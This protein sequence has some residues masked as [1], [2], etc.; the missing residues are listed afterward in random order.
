MCWGGRRSCWTESSLR[1][2]GASSAFWVMIPQGLQGG[3]V[4]PLYQHPG[5]RSWA[6]PSGTKEEPQGWEGCTLRSGSVALSESKQGQEEAEEWPGEGQRP[7]PPPR[8]GRQGRELGG[9]SSGAG[10]DLCSVH[11]HMTQHLHTSYWIGSLEE[12]RLQPDREGSR[13]TAA[14]DVTSHRVRPWGWA[15]PCCRGVTPGHGVRGQR[16]GPGGWLF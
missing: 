16:G 3:E 4:S 11:W 1:Q 13:G 10:R 8:D 2:P 12:E 5:M 6:F 9:S 7:L 14:A 15:V